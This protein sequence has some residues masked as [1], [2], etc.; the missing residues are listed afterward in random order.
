MVGMFVGYIYSVSHAL[1]AKWRHRRGQGQ[2]IFKPILH[3]IDGGGPKDHRV[4]TWAI[5]VPLFDFLTPDWL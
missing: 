3:D 2:T 1:E 5:A 4:G